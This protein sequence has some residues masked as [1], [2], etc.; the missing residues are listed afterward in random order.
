MLKHPK[1]TEEFIDFSHKISTRD[2]RERLV[3]LEEYAGN[4]N[5]KKDPTIRT[6]AIKPI[7][8]GMAFRLKSGGSTNNKTFIMD[9]PC[10]QDILE[11]NLR[12]F[13][14]DL[15]V[16]CYE[17]PA[18]EDLVNLVLKG[19]PASKKNHSEVKELGDAHGS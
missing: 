13:G 7:L 12:K 18:D 14:S 4:Y 3:V 5:P 16:R 17:T 15:S 2:I 6:Q 8:E 19:V 11:T 9:G 10:Y 1:T